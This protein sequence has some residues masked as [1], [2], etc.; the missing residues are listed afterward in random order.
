MTRA[1]AGAWLAILALAGCGF[2]LRTWNFTTTFDTARIDAEHGVDLDIDLASALES[3]GV[4]LVDA[5]A[6]V[7]VRLSDQRD[8]WRSVS[9]TRG[10]RTAEY[11]M[12]LQ[13]TFAVDDG[14]G[15]E[16][17]AARVLRSERVARLD[18]DNL[19]GSSEERRL[20]A[21]EAREDLVDRMVRTLDALSR[22]PEPTDADPR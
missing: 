20:L 19:I 8:D 12:A 22:R 10:A 1:S 3:A 5:D 15:A 7:V 4:R 16:L 14:S 11:E 2:Q 21:A 13:V 9:V 18:R 6:A 17:A